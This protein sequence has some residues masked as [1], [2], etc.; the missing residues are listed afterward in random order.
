MVEK[1]YVLLIMISNTIEAFVLRN[2]G[3]DF[4][5]ILLWY[6]ITILTYVIA[7]RFYIKT[8]II[9]KNKG[10][11]FD[12]KVNRLNWFFM[13]L[14]ITRIA[15]SLL[16]GYGLAE[17]TAST[18]GSIL[19]SLFSIHSI[20]MIYYCIARREKDRKIY[21]INIGLYV[22]LRMVEGYTG[23][24]IIITV[25][26][27]YF[28]LKDR[29]WYNRSFSPK[30]LGGII[31]I[32]TFV[33]IVGGYLYS[34][35]R[36]FKYALR[37]GTPYEKLTYSMGV[38]YLVQRFSTL[39]SSVRVA[40]HYEDVVRFYQSQVDFAEIKAFFRPLLPRAVMPVKEFFSVGSAVAAVPSGIYN[41]GI[42]DGVGVVEHAKILLDSDFTTFIIWLNLYILAI[43]FIRYIIR[44]FQKEPGELNMLYFF[45][46]IAFVESGN[47]ETMFSQTHLK[48]LLFIPLMWFL[49]I[50]KI[51][52]RRTR[53]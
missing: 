50:I 15:Y 51:K 53:A 41:F 22:L 47:L 19:F 52:I 5:S 26:E 2:E 13:F 32:E 48:V 35:L 49:R 21:W 28:R 31:G 40:S 33:L 30:V 17:S 4:S 23:V 16:T 24:L 43:V 3:Y 42:S 11:Y 29:R 44:I 18:S 34:F 6:L 10:F 45:F 9:K 25:C 27:F 14:V 1:A 38:S 20:F 37:L 8:R 36:P 7:Y 46:C 12:V 39:S